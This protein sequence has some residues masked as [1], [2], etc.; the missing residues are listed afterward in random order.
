[1]TNEE[2]QK[3]INDFLEGTDQWLKSM[4]KMGADNI[5]PVCGIKPSEIKK[6]QEAVRWIDEKAWLYDDIC[7]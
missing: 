6:L 1:M 5:C 3:V 2:K 4:E 7:K